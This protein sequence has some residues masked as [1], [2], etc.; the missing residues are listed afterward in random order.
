[1]R[2]AAWR[3]EVATSARLLGIKLWAKT[4]SLTSLSASSP[5]GRSASAA[6]NSSNFICKAPASTAAPPKFEMNSNTQR[7]DSVR[8]PL[9]PKKAWTMDEIW[10]R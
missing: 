10:W 5:S 1:M 2:A 4:A 8:T 6:I 7:T 9:R 3:G